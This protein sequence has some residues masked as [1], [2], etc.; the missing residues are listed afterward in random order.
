MALLGGARPPPYLAQQLPEGAETRRPLNVGRGR[1]P[2]PDGGRAIATGRALVGGASASNAGPRSGSR[3]ARAGGVEVGPAQQFAGGAAQK[4]QRSGPPMPPPARPRQD[5]A[6]QSAVIADVKAV[7]GE[8]DSLTELLHKPLL[9]QSGQNGPLY[10]RLAGQMLDGPSRGQMEGR[11]G[12]GRNSKSLAASANIKPAN[13]DDE[14]RKL[15]AR[16]NLDPTKDKNGPYN[17]LD[18]L[19]RNPETGGTFYV[20]NEVA[21]KNLAMLEKHKIT[22]VINCTDSIPNYHERQPGEPIT[23]FRFDITSHYHRARTEAEAVAFVQPMLN[24]VSDALSRGENVMAHCLAGAHRAGTTGVLNLMYFAKLSPKD[25]T[26][27]AKQCRPIIDPICD[28]PMLLA[29]VDRGWYQQAH[30]GS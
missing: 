2:A 12:P 23:Y 8:G 19:W 1:S 18:P 25:A 3:D 20:G 16:L 24:F 11:R 5:A 17:S 30:V 28:F 13:Y 21:A 6:L 27:L 22:H 4:F 10:E 9:Q 29:R 15:W 7:S 14:A 26:F